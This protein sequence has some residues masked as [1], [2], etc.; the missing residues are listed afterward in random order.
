[1]ETGVTKASS[2]VIGAVVLAAGLSTRM[3]RF[4]LTLPWDGTTVIGR[5]VR[6]LEEAGLE[7]VVVVTGHRSDKVARA[8]TGLAARTVYN[9]SYASGEMLSSI[10]VGLLA[11]RREAQAAVICLGDQPQMEAATVRAVLGAGREEEWRRVIVP[12][13]QMRAGHPVLLPRCIWPDILATA[14][15]LR[16]VMKAQGKQIRYID[17]ETSTV[18]ADLDTPRDYNGRG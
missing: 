13:F 11:L 10:Q 9:P 3:G 1:M 12:S 14:G 16:E 4:K 5:V 7:D 15:T 18:L 17:I 8:L 2:S 6:T